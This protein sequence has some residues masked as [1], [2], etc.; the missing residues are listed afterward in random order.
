TVTLREHAL[1]LVTLERL[2][3]TE[4]ASTG[5]SEKIKKVVV[6]NDG[7]SRLGLVVDTLI[8]EEEIVIKALSD[9]FSHV[10][11]ITGASV[12]GDGR[13]ALILDAV[14]LIK[15]AR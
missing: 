9:H 11:G 13:L 15:E 6:I 7:V 10:R 5:I 12:L 2:I 4:T 1:S 14:A 8:G 3:R